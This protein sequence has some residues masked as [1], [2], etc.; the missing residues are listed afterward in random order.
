MIKIALSMLFAVALPFAMV[1]CVADPTTETD[2]DGDQA[3]SSEESVGESQSA[4]TVLDCCLH[5]SLT[6]CSTVIVSACPSG[7]GGTCTY[8]VGG[9][10]YTLN[11]PVSG[12]G[13]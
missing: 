11:C 4:L 2:S 13:G 9:Q 5:P 3:D 6:G 10:N 8:R 1:G 7:G 12:G